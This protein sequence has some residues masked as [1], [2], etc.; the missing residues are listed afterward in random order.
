MVGLGRALGNDAIH[1]HVTLAA[2]SLGL[3]VAPLFLPACRGLEDPS[4][5]LPYSAGSQ[6]HGPKVENE[7]NVELER[8]RRCARGGSSSRVAVSEPPRCFIWADRHVQKTGGTSLR[9]VFKIAESQGRCAFWGYHQY[10]AAWRKALDFLVR[11]MR[12]DSPF[13]L[14]L[15]IEI[16][17]ER[18][19]RGRRQLTRNLSRRRLD[20][21][22]ELRRA[23]PA[24]CRIVTTT[25]VREPYSY[26]KSYFQWAVS[27]MPFLSRTPSANWTA[28]EYFLSFVERHP[29]LQLLSFLHGSQA[30]ELMVCPGSSP[31]NCYWCDDGGRCGPS[32]TA[33]SHGDLLE[34]LRMMDA[35]DVVSP[36]SQFNSHVLHAAE[37]LDFGP[38]HFQV[39]KPTP[40]HMQ[41]HRQLDPV[42]YQILHRREVLANLRRVP[43]GE[44]C[45]GPEERMCRR[46]VDTHSRLDK[47][48][49]EHG[50]KLHKRLRGTPDPASLLQFEGTGSQRWHG[51]VPPPARCTLLRRD[52]A[53][54]IAN[55]SACMPIPPTLQRILDEDRTNS[56]RK[57]MAYTVRRPCPP[58]AFEFTRDPSW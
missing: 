11:F 24:S 48:I 9:D 8:A 37:L 39:H 53:P 2:S 56:S 52:S 58:Q 19:S 28:T 7:A 43:P 57:K 54:A 17:T 50:Q 45:L 49:H 51:G 23:A 36:L 27:G 38:V 6:V 21:L 46:A 14:R 47:A 29:N 44:P 40:V 1:A 15:C 22:H 13:P 34:A 20:V 32:P 30:L 33:S 26:Y 35:I 12:S 55:P 10:D 3:L 42:S 41:V 25:R 16:H 4:S 5:N 31:R 18:F